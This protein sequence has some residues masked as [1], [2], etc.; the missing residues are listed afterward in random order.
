MA[1]IIPQSSR[2]SGWLSRRAFKIF[3]IQVSVALFTGYVGISDTVSAVGFGNRLRGGLFLL[4]SIIVVVGAIGVVVVDRAGDKEWG[5]IALTGSILSLVATASMVVLQLQGGDYPVRLI[6]W[7]S[8]LLLCAWCVFR[9]LKAGIVIKHP[10]RATALLSVST[11][12]PIVSF[13]G[14]NVY[15]PAAAP[16]YLH[17]GVEFGTPVKNSRETA[18]AIPFTLKLKNPASTRLYVLGSTY[19]I[20]GRKTT[21][22]TNASIGKAMRTA[23]LDGRPITRAL[24]SMTF[25]LLQADSIVTPDLFLEPGEEY[26]STRVLIVPMNNKYDVLRL[27]ANAIVARGDR[28]VPTLQ[29]NVVSWDEQGKQVAEA[30]EWVAPKGTPFIDATFK[31]HETSTVRKLTRQPQ[32]LDVWSVLTNTSSNSSGTLQLVTSIAQGD[33]EPKE[34]SSETGERALTRY[35]LE[36]TSPAVIEMSTWNLR[37]SRSKKG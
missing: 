25:E 13:L 11:L 29:Q 17:I 33:A 35:G 32:R 19:S 16:H 34:P 36:Q 6:I 5:Y 8:M 2:P 22:A 30:P 31:M 28:L 12:L 24:A 21:P 7:V 18:V 10:G 37:A 3:L 9:V 4:A 14:P 26:S 27:E 15:Q 23:I 20:A 1:T